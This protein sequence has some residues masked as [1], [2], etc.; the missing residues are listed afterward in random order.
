VNVGVH[1][2]IGELHLKAL[3]EINSRP[4]VT[5]AVLEPAAL[6]AAEADYELVG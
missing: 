6:P 1:L 4:R 5:A 2:T 3:Q